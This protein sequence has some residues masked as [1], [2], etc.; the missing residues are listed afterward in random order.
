MEWFVRFEARR[1]LITNPVCEC[2]VGRMKQGMEWHGM[3]W[4]NE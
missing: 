4:I 1:R 2:A 3:E